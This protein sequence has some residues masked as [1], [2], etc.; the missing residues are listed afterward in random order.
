MQLYCPSC[1]ASFAGTQRCPRC[2]GLLLMPHECAAGLAPRPAPEPLAPPVRATAAGRVFVGAVLALGLYL[3]LRELTTAAALAAHPDPGAWWGSLAGLVAAG[4]AQVAAVALGAVVAASGRAGGLLFGA[5]VGGTCGGLFLAAELAAGAPRTDPVLYAQWGVL[6]AAGAAAG[7][8]AGR[9]WGAV[10]AL[11]LEAADRARLSSSQFLIGPSTGAAR[12][13]AWARVLVGALL[14]VSAMALAEQ[15][16]FSAER[17]TGGALRAGS[18]GQAR[19][20]AFQFAA[21]GAL[22][23]GALAA[24]G[25]GAGLQHGFLTG[26]LAATGVVGLTASRG[27]NLSPIAFL[28]SAT[29]LGGLPAND[30]AG[31]GVAFGCVLGLVALGGCLGAAL[32]LPLAPESMRQRLKLGQD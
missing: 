11:E 7:A 29:N 31:L 5:A 14:A 9:V 23:G 16:R 8:A 15:L 25:T 13:T 32:F 19:F 30:P 1:Q 12:P 2:A 10:P 3:A 17:Y 18:V 22:A 24:A 28:L 21:L 27:E 20:I 4:A 26:A 6:L